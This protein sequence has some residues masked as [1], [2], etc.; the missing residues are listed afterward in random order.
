MNINKLLLPAIALVLGLA[1]AEPALAAP[2]DTFA[3]VD[4][5]DEVVTIRVVNQNWHDMRIFAIV[6]GLSLRLGTVTGFTT[7]TLKI[8][9][10]LIGF[11][12]DLE[13]VAFGLGNRSSI[14]SGHIVVSPGDQLEFRV[15]NTTGAS[16]LFRV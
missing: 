12:A 14:R 3:A 15:E 6:D 4:K 10:S 13:L 7:R 11:G 16:F 8:R 5:A 2:A 9:R 1:H